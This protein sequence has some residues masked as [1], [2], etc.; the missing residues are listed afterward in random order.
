MG[1]L[2]NIIKEIIISDVVGVFSCVDVTGQTLICSLC[3]GDV[4]YFHYSTIPHDLSILRSRKL[5]WQ[6]VL[7]TLNSIC[8]QF[9]LDSDLESGIDPHK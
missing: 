8:H 6:T 4:E 1:S 5:Q 7:I 2:I 3:P 9:H